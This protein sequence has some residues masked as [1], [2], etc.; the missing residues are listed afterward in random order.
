MRF[1]FLLFAPFL[2]ALAGYGVMRLL[3]STPTI[4][5]PLVCGISLES[6]CTQLSHYNIPLHIIHYKND[7]DVPHNTVIGQTPSAYQTMRSGQTMFLTLSQKPKAPTV[8]DFYQKNKASIN[9]LCASLDIKP[10]YY[11]LALDFCKHQCYAQ[12]PAPRS[13]FFNHH[14]MILYTAIGSCCSSHLAQ[15]CRKTAGRSCP[16][17]SIPFYYTSYFIS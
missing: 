6:A 7:T 17:F 10:Q 3:I 9:T 12:Y 14:A 2:S 5:A 1:P 11:S 13:S 15:F 16:I 4:Q 8:P